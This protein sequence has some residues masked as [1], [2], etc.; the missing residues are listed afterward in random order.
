MQQ[1]IHC[2]Q[3]YIPLIIETISLLFRKYIL[4]DIIMFLLFFCEENI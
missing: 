2:N 4:Q 3:V 1:E